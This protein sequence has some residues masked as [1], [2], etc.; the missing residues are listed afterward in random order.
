MVQDTRFYQTTKIPLFHEHYSG[1]KK[2][3]F[4]LKSYYS[5]ICILLSPNLVWR[6]L[7][8]K[9]HVSIWKGK[10]EEAASDWNHTNSALSMGCLT[11]S[12]QPSQGSALPKEKTGDSGHVPFPEWLEVS[13]VSPQSPQARLHLTAD[14]LIN[15]QPL[16]G[17]KNVCTIISKVESPF[18]A[19]NLCQN[20]NQRLFTSLF[21]LCLGYL[22][23]KS[24]IWITKFFAT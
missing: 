7:S 3:I 9:H 14:M 22:W 5:H 10:G 2:H 6:I 18:L 15:E 12:S 19:S 21:P 11:L 4:V 16:D 24:T 20:V 13:P 23:I 8:T 1:F 17:G